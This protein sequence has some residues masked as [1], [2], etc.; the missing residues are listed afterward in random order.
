[1]KKKI[2]YVCPVFNEEENVPLF[3]KALT[4]ATKK[5][6]KKYE[7]EFLFVNDGSRDSSLEKLHAL[8]KKDERVKIISFSRNFGHQLAITAGMDHAVGDAVIVMDTDLQDPPE[9]SLE[10]IKQWENG[11]HVAYAQRRTR[12]DSFFKK[13]TAAV[14]Y[15]LMRKLSRIDIPLNVG[16][17]RLIDRRVVEVLKECREQHRYVRGMVSFAGFRQTAVLFDRSKREFGESK[18][19]LRKMIK[20]AFDGLTGFSDAP[21]K[22][23]N[24]LS[25][26]TISLAF[27]GVLY[28]IYMRIF[29]P[30]QTVPGWSLLMIVMLFMNS[31]QMMLIGIIGQYTGRIYTEAQKRPLYI[32]QDKVGLE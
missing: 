11:F 17:F 24:T 10:L 8:R 32:I 3:Y 30:E 14:Y 20:L 1:M 28:V 15:K 7:L 16:D 18:Y 22:L 19:P 4:E 13:L 21:L 6:E 9:V 5:I 23:A 25:I 31:V 26:F 2:S 27:L 29:H 12:Q